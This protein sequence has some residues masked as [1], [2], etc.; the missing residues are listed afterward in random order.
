[1]MLPLTIMFAAV[2]MTISLLSK[3]SKEANS[4]VAPLMLLVLM[5]AMAALV[6]GFDLNA[7]LA[8]IPVLNVSLVSKE[9]LTGNYPWLLILLVFGS[10]CA[11]TETGAAPFAA[12]QAPCTM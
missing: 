6:P 12:M 10:S 3:T 7:R 9:V 2:L 1:M 5:P 11:V 4:Y 8:L